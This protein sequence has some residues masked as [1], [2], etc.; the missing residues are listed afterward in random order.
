LKADKEISA[1][2]ER[3][4]PYDIPANFKLASSLIERED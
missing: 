1:R 4:F 3:M 2:R